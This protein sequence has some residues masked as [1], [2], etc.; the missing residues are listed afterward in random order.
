MKPTQFFDLAAKVSL[1]PQELLNTLEI[2]NDQTPT[3]PQ[4]TRDTHL[5]PTQLGRIKRVLTDYLTAAGSQL[6]LTPS[7]KALL[8]LLKRDYPTPPTDQEL[9]EN[10]INRRRQSNLTSK[11]ELD[12]FFCTPETV[13]QRVNQMRAQGS[14]WGQQVL[15]LGD[16]DLTSLATLE[17]NLA[18]LIYVVDIDTDVL[19]YLKKASKG[20]IITLKYDLRKPLPKHLTTRFE[21]IFSDPPYTPEGFKLFLIRSLQALKDSPLSTI[22]TCY[23]YTQQAQERGQQIQEIINDQNLIITEKIWAFNTYLGAEAIGSQ[24]SL[25]Q[26]Q[27]TPETKMPHPKDEKTW[28]KI[29][30]HETS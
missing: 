15:F 20:K 1:N 21:T 7:G 11:R 23:G 19:D 29:Y 28:K 13:T 12:Q 6:K 8:N 3:H 4:L 24:S 30:T 9:T 25:Y 18:S 26:I 2:I 10:I 14:L 17:T 16:H 27:T 5:T 22:Y